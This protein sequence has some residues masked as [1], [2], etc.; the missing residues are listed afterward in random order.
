MHKSCII[1]SSFSYENVK[2]L[3]PRY[4]PQF[5]SKSYISSIVI[6]IRLQEKITISKNYLNMVVKKF[7]PHILGIKSKRTNSSSSFF[8]WRNANFATSWMIYFNLGK[9]QEI[10]KEKCLFLNYESYERIAASLCF[11][12]F[13]T[14]LLERLFH[15]LIPISHLTWLK[16]K[17]TTLFS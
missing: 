13:H 4:N 12:H 16:F 1:L 7:T 17:I 15:F 6:I 9:Y 8:Q 10:K 3:N 14:D 2:Y 5:L 11:I